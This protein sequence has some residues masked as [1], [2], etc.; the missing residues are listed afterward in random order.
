[1]GNQQSVKEPKPNL[2]TLGAV[3][4]IRSSRKPR[5]PK[6]SR[7]IGSNNIFT[8]HHGKFS[9]SFMLLVT[10]KQ[11]IKEIPSWNLLSKGIKN[12]NFM[13]E[14][15]L[16]RPRSR[17]SYDFCKD[18]D[19]WCFV[20]SRRAIRYIR[21]RNLRISFSAPHQNNFRLFFFLCALRPFLLHYLFHVH[22]VLNLLPRY[23]S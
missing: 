8:E 5:V 14:N 13:L 9:H 18:S 19:L 22:K 2:S 7:I 16:L 1:M 15:C 4:S 10:E 11:K 3:S 23:V 20:L 21:W 12:G 17:F 6:D